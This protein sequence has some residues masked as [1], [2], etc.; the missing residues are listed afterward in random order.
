MF[1]K[2]SAQ[3]TKQEESCLR[4]SLRVSIFKAFISISLEA[5]L[6]CP[7]PAVFSGLG[8]LAACSFVFDFDRLNTISS[9]PVFPTLGNLPVLEPDLQG[10]GLDIRS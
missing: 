4:S 7:D 10:F 5:D 8:R 1:A 2:P 6:R 3:F 9:R